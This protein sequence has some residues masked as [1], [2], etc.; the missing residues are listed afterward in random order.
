MWH[1][2]RLCGWGLVY[3]KFSLSY[4][5]VGCFSFITS[6]CVMVC[7]AMFPQQCTLQAKRNLSK[8]LATE[9]GRAANSL[10][11]LE[12]CVAGMETEVEQGQCREPLTFQMIA[13]VTP[14]YV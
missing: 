1:Y 12:R 2:I 14:V 11:A 13:P 9:A 6:L 5:N 7:P 8:T 10:H 4:C 3:S